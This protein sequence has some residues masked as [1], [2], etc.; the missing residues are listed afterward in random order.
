M[1]LDVTM[2]LEMLMIKL[3]LLE[4]SSVWIGHKVESVTSRCPI[5]QNCIPFVILKYEV[6]VCLKMIPI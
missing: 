3:H 2:L 4:R 6:H 1:P 5:P